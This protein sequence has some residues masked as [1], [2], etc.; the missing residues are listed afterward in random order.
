M[1]RSYAI[2]LL[3]GT[4]VSSAL[5]AGCAS[6]ASRVQQASVPVDDGIVY[7]M[8][9]RPIKVIVTVDAQGVQTPSVGTIEA[10]PDLRHRFVL[11]YEQNLVGKNHM[12]IGVNTRGLLTS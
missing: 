3:T 1:Q 6:Y 11:H 8:P 12:S 5:A 2:F 4:L 10:S 9:N 7:Y